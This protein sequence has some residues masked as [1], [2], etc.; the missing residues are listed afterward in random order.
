MKRMLIYLCALLLVSSCDEEKQ[1]STHLTEELHEVGKLEL[2]EY[3][4]EEIF[5]IS[6][7]EQSLKPVMS[8]DEIA[9]YLD[10]KLTVGDRIGVY[11][12]ENFS[13]A[14]IDLSQ[15]RDEDITF[16]ASNKS[17]RLV[18]PSVQVEPIGRSGSIRKLHERITGMQGSISSEERRLMQNQAS[19]LAIEA[20]APGTPKH[21]DLVSK[22]EQKACAYFTGMLHARGCK[23]VTIIFKS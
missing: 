17:I 7:K 3:R 12:F 5:I 6:P 10:S 8:L 15:L 11:S 14:Y 2:I 19:K 20:L 9:N 22:A 4:T 21:K 23:E 16:D 1:L 13:V 18:L